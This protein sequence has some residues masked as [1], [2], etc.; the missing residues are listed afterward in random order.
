MQKDSYHHSLY[1]VN[2][3]NW[4]LLYIS[5]Q[6]ITWLQLKTFISTAVKWNLLYLLNHNGGDHNDVED[7]HMETVC[8][9]LLMI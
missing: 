1:W 7:L 4:L 5:N 8:T 2:L 9:S 3:S 6:P